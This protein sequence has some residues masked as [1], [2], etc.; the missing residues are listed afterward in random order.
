ML[1]LEENNPVLPFSLVKQAIKSAFSCM[2]TGPLLAAKTL[3]ITM[4]TGNA[5]HK[6]QNPKSDTGL[7]ELFSP[8]GTAP[9]RCEP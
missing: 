4:Q 8:L 2:H 3:L 6:Q 9:T 7:K 1:F 5:G